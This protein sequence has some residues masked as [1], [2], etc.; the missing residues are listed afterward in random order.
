[1]RFTS[2]LGGGRTLQRFMSHRTTAIAIARAVL[3]T[4]VSR[5]QILERMARCTAFSEAAD[6]TLVED[7]KSVV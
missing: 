3:A 2:R 4:P 7:R 1:M 6:R 5:T